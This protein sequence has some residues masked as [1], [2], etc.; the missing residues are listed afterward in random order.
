MTVPADFIGR[1]GLGYAF[2]AFPSA[3]LA[4][5]VSHIQRALGRVLPH[6]CWFMPPPTLHLT[7][8]EI[9]ES[10]VYEQDKEKLYEANK[11]LYV[12]GAAQAFSGMPAF[13]VRFH[14]I[15][16]SADAI[17][18][19]G[20]DGGE[21]NALRRR[22]LKQFSLPQE[23]KMPPPIIHSTIARYTQSIPLQAVRQAVKE[24]R[25]S[26]VEPITEF[27]LLKTTIRPL[28]EYEVLARYPLVRPDV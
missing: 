11:D 5:E 15:E 28:L 20:E 1:Y 8:C 2:V 25:L 4:E 14:R 7:L 6:S 9:I 3:A 18:V 23:T 17:I 13:S 10:K 21:F 26:I 16:A 24:Q 19:R 12:A 27:V 22:L